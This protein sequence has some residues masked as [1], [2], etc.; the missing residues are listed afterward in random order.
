MFS[1]AA[2]GPPLGLTGGLGRANNELSHRRKFTDPFAHHEKQRD[3][4]YRND[5]VPPIREW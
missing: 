1:A 4:I 3:A 5:L 2:S